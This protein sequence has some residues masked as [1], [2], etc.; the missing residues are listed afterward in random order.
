MLFKCFFCNLLCSLLLLM[1]CS[2]I[3]E[4]K[5]HYGCIPNYILLLCPVSTDLRCPSKVQTVSCSMQTS[6]TYLNF[7]P[8][9]VIFETKSMQ[10]GMQPMSCHLCAL[11]RGSDD[12][13][14]L[15]L[16]RGL[17]VRKACC[18]MQPDEVTPAY[19]AFDA[20]CVGTYFLFILAFY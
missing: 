9:I 6:G 16:H 10:F 13:T 2:A 12:V 5:K 15:P 19:T 1:D 14:Y 3:L 17:W 4:D 8:P 20:L 7:D 18:K 11:S